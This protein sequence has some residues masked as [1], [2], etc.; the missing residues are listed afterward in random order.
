MNLIDVVAN[1]WGS[2]R[3]SERFSLCN[4]RDFQPANKTSGVIFVPCKTRV[5]A[6][7]HLNKLFESSSARE[8]S[9]RNPDGYTTAN[10]HV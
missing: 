5:F 9:V 3:I 2:E 10:K 8:F 1:M 6:L 4:V 7:T